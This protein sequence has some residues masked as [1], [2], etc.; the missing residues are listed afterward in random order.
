M[1]LYAYKNFILR[2]VHSFDNILRLYFK[3]TNLILKGI[4]LILSERA[5]ICIYVVCM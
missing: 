1:Y 3:F 5:G 4:V 2:I